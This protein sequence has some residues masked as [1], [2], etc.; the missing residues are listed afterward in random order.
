[1]TRV[2]PSPD[3]RFAGGALLLACAVACAPARARAECGD[4]VHIP[5]G[6]QAAD[7]QGDPAPGPKP[8]HGPNC[9]KAPAAP[10][11]PLPAPAPTPP[12]AKACPAG[13]RDVG[14]GQSSWRLPPA[15]A[16]RPTQLPSSVFHPPRAS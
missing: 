14:D 7:H 15:T 11:T 6:T 9:S 8:C 12:E 10:V 4:Y 16:G 3:L 5:N 1:M 13:L 2:R